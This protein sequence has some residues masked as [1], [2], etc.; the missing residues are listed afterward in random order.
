MLVEDSVI[1]LIQINGK[2]CVEISVLVDMFKEDVE[3][4]VFEYEVV[5]KVLDGVQ[6]KKLIVV[7]GWIVNVVI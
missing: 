2:C 7:F 4:F 5:V 6:L 3:K 1:M